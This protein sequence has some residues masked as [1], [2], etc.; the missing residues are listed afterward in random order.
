M[1]TAAF[2][3]AARSLFGGTLSQSQV[4]GLNVILEATHHLPISHRAYLL[5]TTHHETGRTMQPVRETFAKTDDEAI[6]RLEASFAKGQLKWV[7]TPYWRKD[8]DGKSWLGRGYVQLTHKV[9]Y[10]KASMLTGVDLVANPNAAMRPAVAAK[11]LVE[12]SQM[13]M[14][15]GK[16]LSDYLPGDYV[17]AR[18]IINGV[19]SAQTVAKLAQGYEAALRHIPIGA[20]TPPSAPPS[21]PVSDAAPASPDAAPTTPT[22]AILIIG[23]IAAVAAYLSGVF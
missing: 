22:I 12:G 20:P 15:T 6:R 5:A 3:A 1:T 17:N 9:N 16:K 2:Y 7:K 10:E 23:A 19:E 8:A 21:I 4:D 13:G 11:I 14:F 18:R